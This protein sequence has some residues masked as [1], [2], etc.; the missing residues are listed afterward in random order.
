VASST[1]SSTE[2][3]V[4]VVNSATTTE[5]V[6]EITTESAIATSTTE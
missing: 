2:R 4:N 3:V 6:V 1:A 5:P